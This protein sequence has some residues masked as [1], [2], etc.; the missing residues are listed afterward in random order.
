MTRS[1][2]VGWTGFVGGE[3]L[4]T[5]PD[6]DLYNSSTVQTMANKSYNT[7]YFAGLPAEK[8][9]INK[10]PA[11]DYQTL[12]NIIKILE[13]MTIN[14]FVLISTVDVLD[15]SIEQDETGTAY[16]SH[17][18]GTHRRLMEQWV[19]KNIADYYIIRLPGLFGTGLKKN[20]LYDL[21]HDNLV[22]SISLSSSF[23]YYNIENLKNDIDYC[24]YEKR[25]LVHLLSPPIQTETIVRRF[26][27]DKI[28][29]CKGISTVTYKLETKYGRNKYWRL[30][31][32]VLDDIGT[33]IQYELD[34][35]SLP[36]KIAVSNIAWNYS[37]TDD[38]LKILNRYHIKNLEVALT[39]TASWKE[40]DK[41]VETMLAKQCKYVSCQSILFD[42][43]INIYEAPEAFVEHYRLVSSVCKKI[44]VKTVVFG[45][46]KQ[47]HTLGKPTSFI[48]PYFKQ[49][50]QISRDNN[51][52]FCIEPNATEYGC[53]WLTDISKV[54][55]FL[56]ELNED[57]VRLNFDTGNFIMEKDK[58]EALII[59]RFYIGNVQVSNRF[60][61]PFSEID[62]NDFDTFK[63]LITIML[64]SGYNGTISLE[65]RESNT[66][67]LMKS[68]EK[69]ISL[70][71]QKIVVPY[72]DINNNSANMIFRGTNYVYD[73]QRHY[74][75]EADADRLT[76]VTIHAGQSYIKSPN[77]F[78]VRLN[79]EPPHSLYYTLP[80]LEDE[81]KN[82]D[83]VY[84]I[85]PYTTRYLNE[86]YNTNKVKT[87]FFPLQLYECEERERTIPV[88]Y[89]GNRFTTIE[90][91]MIIEKEV[92][93]RITNFATICSEIANGDGYYKKL[94]YLAATKIAL[95][96][97]VLPKT[98]HII[99][100]NAD[101]DPAYKN[102]F[103]WHNSDIY[104]PQIKS[105]I[106][107]GAMMGC[108][109]LVY[110]DET[111]LHEMYFTENEDFIYFTDAEDLTKKVDMI[112]ENYDDY[113][114]MAKRAQQKMKEKYTLKGFI[115]IILK[116]KQELT[117][118]G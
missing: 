111:R 101:F 12:M 97:N 61:K 22:D 9:R 110:K 116:D 89:T 71:R 56:K 66:Y 91:Y 81:V 23:Q 105:R 73:P 30:A 5:I 77:T 112:L 92:N 76:G 70:F 108:V 53:T 1:A 21:I 42:T 104:V 32:E 98:N 118:I 51:L 7:I 49:I 50:A 64:M 113:I 107:E 79:V 28:L 93:K 100:Y 27:P 60:L 8:W 38:I 52:L 36:V 62:T 3:L 6:V 25:R 102:I 47:R 117:S 46:P 85:C 87:V 33:F 41:H 75:T 20:V 39:K 18:Y 86:K 35:L 55:E 54:I 103:P 72:K 83:L 80:Q 16:T 14:R 90:V 15:C 106:F 78:N 96:H 48:I 69:F 94:N 31:N 11:S 29:R 88:L 2:I 115:D 26:F 109:L 13:T 37:D 34:I 82:F 95:V 58:L 45:S 84:H 57:T 10:E 43:G 24:I 63:D 68:L 17:P 74:N 4:R 99:D 65:M 19:E 59:N 40:L 114:P 67:V 44:G